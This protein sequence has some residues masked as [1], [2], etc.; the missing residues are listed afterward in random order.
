MKLRNQDVVNKIDNKHK[1]KKIEKQNDHSVKKSPNHKWIPT[2]ITPVNAALNAKFFKNK[3]KP[4]IDLKYSDNEK[5]RSKS[6]L[7]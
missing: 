2:N 6:R 4:S 7:R 5:S 1:I 3:E